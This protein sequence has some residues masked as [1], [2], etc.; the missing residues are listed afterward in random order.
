[1]K[2]KVRNIIIGISAFMILAVGMIGSFFP[3]AMIFVKETVQSL[4]TGEKLTGFQ[5]NA[6]KSI[7]EMLFYHNALM[8]LNS[9]KENILNTRIIRKDDIEIIKSDSGKLMEASH[10]LNKK[11]E[12]KKTA[13]RLLDLQEKAERE[14]AG[15]LYFSLPSKSYYETCPVNVSDT[16]RQNYDLYTNYMKQRGVSI[17]SLTDYVA[18]NDIPDDSLYFDTDHHWKPYTG[19]LAAKAISEKLQEEYGFLPD[20]QALDIRNYTITSYQ[21]RFLGSLGKKV[22]SWFTSNGPDDFELIVPAFDTLFEENIK[23]DDNDHSGSFSET[24]LHMNQLDKEDPYDRNDYAVYCGGDFRLQVFK[25]LQK[26]NGKKILLIRDS[27][28]C[29]AAPFLALQAS[30]LH[31]VDIRDASYIKGD[32]I[33]VYQYI[34]QIRPDY[35]IVLYSR[36]QKYNSSGGRF[37][38]EG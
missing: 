33:N 37:D 23:Y 16:T 17:L 14:G 32:R 5:N 6:D 29:A 3:D 8:D 36:P 35:V 12:Y 31:I 7:S 30:E 4:N 24:V 21:N 38:F 9:V 28:G 25:N 15:F 1:M 13:D 11:K 2:I 18:E 27:F 19:F 26:E 34:E 22:G 10:K 20:A